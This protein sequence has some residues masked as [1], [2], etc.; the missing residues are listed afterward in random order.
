MLMT[1]IELINRMLE[2]YHEPN[3]YRS[4][5]NN[6]SNF[7]GGYWQVDCSCSIKTILN[8]GRFIPENR[9]LR[10]AGANYPAYFPDCTCEGFL[11]Y[12]VVSTDFNN[13]E[14]GEIVVMY[15]YGHVGLYI[16]N[17]EVCEVTHAWTG[18]YPGCHIS[19][20]DNMGTRINCGMDNGRWSHHVK[21]NCI[22]YINEQQEEQKEEINNDYQ[23]SSD[24]KE[25]EEQK[26]EKENENREISI[27]ELFKNILKL[28]KS[29][30]SRK[31]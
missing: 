3:H 10:H 17:G 25:Y 11:N 2:L 18:G 12:G 28:I 13:I 8:M 6:F 20:I 7:E 27:I 24:V 21:L 19:K 23:E 22:E 4:G 29:L 31:V 30:F 15:G 5:G 14:P 26:E 9:G 1:N 16:G